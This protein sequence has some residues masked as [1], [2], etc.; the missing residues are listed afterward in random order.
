VASGPATSQSVLEQVYQAA[1]ENVIAASRLAGIH[2]RNVIGIFTGHNRD[3][4]YNYQ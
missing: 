1:P 3:S 2:G 4:L